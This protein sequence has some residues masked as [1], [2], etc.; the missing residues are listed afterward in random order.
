MS[1]DDRITELEIR[2]THQDSTIDELNQTVYDQWKT[3]ES[4]T[5]DILALKDRFKA[6]QPSNIDDAPYLPPHF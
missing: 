3:I 2:L 5:K 6:V 4:L 1:L